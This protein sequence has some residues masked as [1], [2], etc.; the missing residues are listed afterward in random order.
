MGLFPKPIPLTVVAAM[1]Q[2]LAAVYPESKVL[3]DQEVEGLRFTLGPRII[4]TRS[5]DSLSF[6]AGFGRTADSITCPVCHMTSY[7]PKDIKEGFCGNCNAWT[8]DDPRSGLP[9]GTDKH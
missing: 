3:M 1:L 5:A 2:G 4:D 6:G 9:L 7:H 8:R